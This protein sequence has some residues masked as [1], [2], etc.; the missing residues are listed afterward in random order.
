M[1]EVYDTQDKN[2]GNQIMMLNIL[3]FSITIE[4]KERSEEDLLKLIRIKGIEDELNKVKNQYLY[5]NLE[6]NPHIFK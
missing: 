4:K 2:G 5:Q 1:A 3:N 6:I